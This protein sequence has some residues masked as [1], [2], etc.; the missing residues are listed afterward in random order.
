MKATVELRNQ[1]ETRLRQQM[2][3]TPMRPLPLFQLTGWN[4][5]VE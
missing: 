1:R 3:E 5:F 4:H 2:R